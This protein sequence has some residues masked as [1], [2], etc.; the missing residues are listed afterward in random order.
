MPTHGRSAM[1]SFGIADETQLASLTRILDDYC[2]EFGIANGD[3][4]ARK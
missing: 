3:K 1:R 2:T 4:P